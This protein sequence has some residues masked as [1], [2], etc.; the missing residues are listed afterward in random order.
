M[1]IYYTNYTGGLHHALELTYPA[2][3]KLVGDDFFRATAHEFIASHKPSST[4][5]DDYGEEFA[6]FLGGFKPAQQLA[7]LPDVARLEWAFHLSSNA[8][9]AAP[10][11]PDALQGL[12]EEAFA[13]LTFVAHP[14]VQLVHS[15]HA[16]HRIWEM[17]QEG[18]E[19]AEPFDLASA[20]EAHLLLHRPAMQVQIIA[21]PAAE[22]HFIHS[23]HQG[24]T[25]YE[26][27]EAATAHDGDFDLAISMQQHMV[28]GTFTALSKA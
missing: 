16:I 7:Y 27:Y 14:T 8:D 28:R 24:E 22:Y 5:L 11:P 17:C 9:R 21:L 26:A 13:Q 10:V 18:A 3:Q 23:L 2:I 6:A 4:N 1:D 19:N 15:P 20:G 12:S 25:L